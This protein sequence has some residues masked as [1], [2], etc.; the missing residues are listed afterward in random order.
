MSGPSRARRRRHSMMRLADRRGAT[1]VVCDCPG[2]TRPSSLGISRSTDPDRL[3][4]VAYPRLGTN[5]SLGSERLDCV[6][7]LI[8]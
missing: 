1:G 7:E 3:R 4:P 5:T 6:I 8:D 2:S